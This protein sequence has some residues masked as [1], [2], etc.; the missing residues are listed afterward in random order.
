MYAYEVTVCL[1]LLATLV[2]KILE[3]FLSAAIFKSLLKMA[4]TIMTVEFGTIYHY[5]SLGEILKTE[6]LL[7]SSL[8]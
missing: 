7:C 3:Y 2:T 1:I 6:G 4:A 8:N 5:S